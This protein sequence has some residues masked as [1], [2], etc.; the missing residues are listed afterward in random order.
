MGGC[1]AGCRRRS[2]WFSANYWKQPAISTK[3][4]KQQDCREGR[5]LGSRLLAALWQVIFQVIRLLILLYISRQSLFL[6]QEHVP[7]CR[8]VALKEGAQSRPLQQH[9][10]SASLFICKKLRGP[11][12]FDGVRRI[13]L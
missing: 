10:G 6:P 7:R 13:P 11:Y 5:C 8:H 9:L 4:C 12:H 3:Y 2:R 1:G